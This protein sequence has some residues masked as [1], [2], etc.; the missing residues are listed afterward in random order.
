MRKVSGRCIGILGGTF[1]PIHYGHL[2]T[3][4][5]LR[6]RLGLDHVRFIPCN[7]PPTS[8]QPLLDA[9]TRLRIVQAA[10]ASE[11]DFIADDRELVRGNVSY[12]VDTLASLRREFADRPLALIMGMDA[13]LGLPSWRDWE[14][15][16]EYAHI[17]VAHRPG[18][19]VPQDGVP[20]RLIAERSADSSALLHSESSG[21]VY[22][23]EVTQ[24]EISSTA[25][26]T[27]ISEGVDPKFLVPPAVRSI[28][29][30]LDCYAGTAAKEHG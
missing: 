19:E 15:L 9:R 12:T 7:D 18:F 13:F 4:L 27:S 6:E 3:A 11:P 14:R 2:R 17:V 25:L 5:E 20:G 24:L 22:V 1:D 21:R 8:K 28:I 26:R 30:E 16:F 29:L 23:A 10:I